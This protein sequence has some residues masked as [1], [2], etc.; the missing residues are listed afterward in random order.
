MIAAN[1]AGGAAD[2]ITGANK[3]NNKEDVM[4]G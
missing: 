4:T 2:M 3:P 1:V